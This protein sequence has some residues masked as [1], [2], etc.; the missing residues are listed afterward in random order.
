[1]GVSFYRFEGFDY[2]YLGNIDGF[3]KLRN[4]TPVARGSIFRDLRVSLYQTDFYF[5]VE[6]VLNTMSIMIFRVKQPFSQ[7][8][9]QSLSTG[10]FV[11][12][13]SVG[14]ESR[15][16]KPCFS[17]KSLV[18][19]KSIQL[20]HFPENGIRLHEFDRKKIDETV[21]KSHSC[22]RCRKYIIWSFREILTHHSPHEVSSEIFET[23]QIRENP[24]R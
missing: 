20:W 7:L 11:H 16:I 5:V 6:I 19:E 22:S 8:W 3:A 12:F 24:F 2:R 23:K 13:L 4:R 17:Q 10:D 1:M 21:L 18:P 15:R 14:Q 9:F